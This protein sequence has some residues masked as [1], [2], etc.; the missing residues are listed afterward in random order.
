MQSSQPNPKPD[1]W[2]RI[3][4]RNWQL[5][6]LHTGQEPGL[7]FRGLN[8]F[9]QAYIQKGPETLRR[10]GFCLYKENKDVAISVSL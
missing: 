7:A 1:H 10:A 2:P 3:E 8:P 6:L 5:E 9:Q 4:R